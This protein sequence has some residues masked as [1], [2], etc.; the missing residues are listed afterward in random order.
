MHS[1]SESRNTHHCFRAV[2][3]IRSSRPD[4]LCPHHPPFSSTVPFSCIVFPLSKS[5][6][7]S[8]R[9]GDSALFLL[10]LAPLLLP[11]QPGGVCC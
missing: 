8:M 5:S 6:L 9:S 4:V 11:R 10:L 3:S 1:V 7:L 2:L